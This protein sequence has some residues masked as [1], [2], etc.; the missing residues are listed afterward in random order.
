MIL[1]LLLIGLIYL[2]AKIP[3]L[4]TMDSS[5]QRRTMFGTIFSIVAGLA[6][7]GWIVLHF[8]SQ[9]D[10]LGYS[11]AGE[12]YKFFS[13]YYAVWILLSVVVAPVIGFGFV[14]LVSR[15]QSTEILGSMKEGFLLW[16][17]SIAGIMVAFCAIGYLLAL[18]NGFG[19][20]TFVS[21]P[22]AK[23]ESLGRLP[24]T[25]KFK[26]QFTIAP[27]PRN[28][29]PEEIEV[30]IWG[31]ELKTINF[32]TNERLIVSSVPIGPNPSTEDINKIIDIPASDE[33]FKFVK[34]PKNDRIFPDETTKFEKL[35]F[36]N[37]GDQPAEVTMW[38]E[39]EPL[40]PQAKYIPFVAICV[41][42]LFMAYLFLSA[43]MPK[44]AAISLSTFKNEISQPIF[45]LLA[46]LGIVFILASI[47]IPYNTLGEDIKMYKEGGL[48]FIRVLA[49]FLAVWSASKSVA[50]EIEGRTALTVLSKPVGR[51]QF[52][53]GKFGGIGLAVG[54]LFII[55]GVW[56]C[57]WTSYKPIY[58]GKETAMPDVEWTIGFTEMMRIVPGLL[59]GYMEVLIFVAISVA[60]STRMGI[61][62]NF[63]ICFAVYV[64]GH[65][66]PLIIQS[67]EVARAFEPVQLFGR[68]IAT[69]IPVLDHF[70]I[71]AAI[72]GEGAVPMDYVGWCIVYCLMYGAMALLFALVLFEDRDLA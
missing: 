2:L 35:Y 3:G 14:A 9:T 7:I 22:N 23:L 58:D 21:Q 26:K 57:I 62:P 55:L 40:Y 10:Y 41:V 4:N 71:Q 19:V 32:L 70:D 5:P 39:S 38:W 65:L 44:I 64:M 33:K 46:A 49:I 59:L 37:D 8:F 15:K 50:E 68:V 24:Y 63:L 36:R 67:N 47:Y 30:L 6:L 51:R 25:G 56:F 18:V 54:L 16:V 29:N 53:V 1:V 66:T 52:I 17:T 42:S 31:F 20:I 11:S 27:T 43:A 45:I 72:M 12:R 61:L 34:R 48:T 69:I 28:A 13:Q 60:I